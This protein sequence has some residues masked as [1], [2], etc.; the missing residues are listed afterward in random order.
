MPEKWTNGDAGDGAAPNAGF[1]DGGVIAPPTRWR[2]RRGTP[3]SRRLLRVALVAVVALAATSA[4]VFAASRD[5]SNPALQGSQDM[6]IANSSA[7]PV[8]SL[9]DSSI[10]GPD[11]TTSA[12]SVALPGGTLVPV[13]EPITAVPGL[14]DSA[15]STLHIDRAI[16]ERLEQLLATSAPS[17]FGGVVT[18]EAAGIARVYIAMDQ[19]FEMA[20][21]TL[22]PL[23]EQARTQVAGFGPQPVY[24]ELW[25]T[26]V[27]SSKTYTDYATLYRRIST[28][29]W[30]TDSA[31]RVLSLSSDY[32]HQVVAAGVSDRTDADVAAAAASFGTDV[33]VDDGGTSKGVEGPA[34]WV[35]A[36]TFSPTPQSVQ[37]PLLVSERACAGGQSAEGRITPNVAY[38]ATSVTITITVLSLGGAQTC[39]GPPPTPYT[40][41]LSESL[42]NRLLLGAAGG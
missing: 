12:G 27:H 32:D 42:G 39:P 21:T 16:A 36:P 35:L 31:H 19:T 10:S 9:V 24:P 11:G 26:L 6:S 38:S 33:R 29:S 18:D 34:T 25:I 4:I 1:E 17:V 8:G 7:A 5:R 3:R 13:R 23:V 20:D 40:V 37:V 2:S 41:R 15:G 22:T 14:G 28:E 30:T